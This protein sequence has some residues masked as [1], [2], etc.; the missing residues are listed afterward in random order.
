MVNST[1]DG[2]EVRTPATVVEMVPER[3]KDL[4]RSGTLAAKLAGELSAGLA[5]G[6]SRSYAYGIPG[7]LAD[8][9][10]QRDIDVLARIS[11]RADSDG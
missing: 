6:I 7:R 5:E 9:L 3:V 11:A 2:T 8:R 1:L 4:R 10:G